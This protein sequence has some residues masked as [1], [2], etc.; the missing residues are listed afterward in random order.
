M[1]TKSSSF[2]ELDSSS[3]AKVSRIPGEGDIKQSFFKIKLFRRVM[4]E[5]KNRALQVPPV[6][7]YKAL[8]KFS[9]ALYGTTGGTCSAQ[10]FRP[11]I[12]SKRQTLST[13]LLLLIRT[14]Y[15]V[16]RYF[17]LKIVSG[18]DL[19]IK[20]HKTREY[21]GFSI[22]RFCEDIAALKYL[23]ECQFSS[24]SQLCMNLG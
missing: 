14:T 15:S 9:K 16:N 19:L 10:F 1:S 17:V 23:N 5:R 8:E 3:S 22:Y 20:I 12:K 2:S 13:N 18:H 11:V 24:P 6:V 4:R 21:R 7:P